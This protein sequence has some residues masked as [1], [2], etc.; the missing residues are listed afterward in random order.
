MPFVSHVTALPTSDPKTI[1]A[2]LADQVCAP[3]LWEKSMRWALAHG[4]RRFLEPGPGEVLAGLL[5]KIDPDAEIRS[6]AT[7]AAVG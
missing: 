5:R 6:V 2:Q 4:L 1:R 7:P 3:V